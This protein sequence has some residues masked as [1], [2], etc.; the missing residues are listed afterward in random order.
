MEAS[1]TLS[2]TSTRPSSVDS[3]KETGNLALTA[4]AWSGLDTISHLEPN[5]KLERAASKLSGLSGP[6]ETP[7]SEDGEDKEYINRVLQPMKLS[8]IMDDVMEL[9]L[10]LETAPVHFCPHDVIHRFQLHT[11]EEV[12]CVRWNNVYYMTGTDIVRCLTYRFAAFGRTITNRKKFEEGIFS[13]LRNLKCNEHAK[14]E[15]AKSEFLSFLYKHNCIRTKKK[16]KVFH[17]FS[18]R[19]DQLFI[20]ALERD[21][22]KESCAYRHT[23]DQSATQAVSEPALSFKYD[24]KQ[25][26]ND[27]IAGAISDLPSPLARIV[28]ATMTPSNVL[29]VGVKDGVVP[30]EV[31]AQLAKSSGGKCSNVTIVRVASE[32]GA[33]PSADR[34]GSENSKVVVLD[35]NQVPSMALPPGSNLDGDAQHSKTSSR[36]PPLGYPEHYRGLKRPV[37][38]TGLL[39][40]L[41]GNYDHYP[42]KYSRSEMNGRSH[43]LEETPY[44]AIL[45]LLSIGSNP[46]RNARSILTA[47]SA[48]KVLTRF[49]PHFRPDLS[50]ESLGMVL[51]RIQGLYLSEEEMAYVE[52]ALALVATARESVGQSAS[53]RGGIL[54]ASNPYVLPMAPLIENDLLPD[55]GDDAYPSHVKVEEDFAYSAH[56]YGLTHDTQLSGPEYAM[57]YGYDAPAGGLMKED[58]YDMPDDHT[59]PQSY[60]SAYPGYHQTHYRG[61]PS[62]YAQ[63]GSGP[64]PTHLHHAPHARPISQPFNGFGYRQP[65]PAM[66]YYDEYPV[67]ND[68][69]GW[70]ARQWYGGKPV[71]SRPLVRR[72]PSRR[73]DGWQ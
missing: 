46:T 12:S 58:G 29:P 43:P 30:P 2:P 8:K 60:H 35:S 44:K 21:L 14:L 53:S 7:L 4:A 65:G 40:T 42:A 55:G 11:E 72:A 5:A 3:V 68:P 22:K 10:F 34:N 62:A 61:Y 73:E 71:H 49:F 41:Q 39:D 6:Q 9:K 25:T 67:E 27:Q 63:Q 26:L 50:G 51:L 59:A 31:Q 23:S 56:G 47:Q 38:D 48:V 32:S 24:H 33:L 57:E 28:N 37:D 20:D 36:T 19:H 70:S 54:G 1:D 64:P 17:W 18:I 13:D 66:S 52:N 45:T 15:G 16:Q 69:E